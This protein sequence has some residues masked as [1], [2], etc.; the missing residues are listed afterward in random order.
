MILRV[1]DDC[2]IQYL[3]LSKK[4]TIRHDMVNWLPIDN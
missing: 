3:F 1:T 2:E 4:S